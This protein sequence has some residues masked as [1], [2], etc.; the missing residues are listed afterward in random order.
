MS[1]K[2][3]DEDKI[4]RYVITQFSEPTSFD[5]LEADN[6][7]NL[8][9][10][11]MIYLT[12]LEVSEGDDLSSDV[13]ENFMYDIS[14]NTILWRVRKNLL[15]SDGSPIQAED[16]AFSVTRMLYTRPHFPT[17][18]Y[19]K[20]LK[21][22]LTKDS[23]LESLPEGVS[24]DGQVIKIEFDRNVKN[25]LYR[26]CLEI[27]SII[28]KKCVD[29]KTNKIQCKEIPTSGK[30]KIESKSNDGW[31]FSQNQ[32]L[33][34]DGPKK[35]LFEFW[36][37]KNILERLQGINE[38]T[39]IHST[40][41]TISLNEQK[42]LKETFKIVNKP[43]SNFFS[44]IMNPHKN[45]LKKAA[46]RRAF[47]MAFSKAFSQREGIPPEASL[48][49]KIISGY[50]SLD[51][52]D[53]GSGVSSNEDLDLCQEQLAQLPLN[54]GI[55]KG[56]ELDPINKLV[57]DVYV[58]LGAKPNPPILYENFHELS[59]AFIG[60]K[61]D[62]SFIGTGF[63][64][65]DPAGDLQMMFTPDLHKPMKFVSEDKKLQKLI[66]ELVQNPNKEWRYK[67]INQHIYNEALI[68][69]YSHL[70]MFY[71]SKNQSFLKKIPQGIT[72]PSPWQVFK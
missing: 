11:R 60:E 45:A 69:A 37:K 14:T 62:F 59:D 34:F 28:P 15:F 39:V 2:K 25:P 56:G 18:K 46:C 19:I 24:I 54:W 53:K 48:F 21:S 10:A 64:A 27:F 22:W 42:K 57:R 8:P 68:R 23:P 20:G 16:V 12:P 71:I 51:E 32:N 26:F 61:I 47:A 63:W 52:L 43:I 17:V 67:E 40:D 44:I 30:Y 1:L 58:S 3:T 9:V 55:V 31:L 49:T 5:P 70:K 6:Y 65:L 38:N 72:A 13:L 66:E 41:Q 35:I 7:N 50:L 29:T 33:N 36:G 4:Y